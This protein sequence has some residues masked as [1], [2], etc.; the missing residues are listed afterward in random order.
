MLGGILIGALGGF[1]AAR[2]L[3]RRFGGGC[4]GGC[5]RGRRGLLRDLNLEGWQRDE[6]DGL[7]L[8]LRGAFSPA[9]ALSRADLAAVVTAVT[10][11][12]LDRGRLEELL[13]QRG[14]ALE[15]AKQ[16]VLAAAEK[17]NRIL[18]PE[19]RERLRTRVG[20]PDLAYADGPYR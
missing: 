10:A 12:P 16:V 8:S 18:T 13:A 4:G 11:E 6:I 7:W 9:I 15:R 20:A 19:Q 1:A 17:L 3:R 14:A 2:C 5:G